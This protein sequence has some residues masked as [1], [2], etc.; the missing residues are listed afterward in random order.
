MQN[1]DDIF[2][3]VKYIEENLTETISVQDVADSIG[4]SLFYFSRIFNAATG[5]SPYDYII[6]RR[7]SQAAFDLF[8]T[9]D[10]II[11]IA[12]NYRFNN[13]ETFSRAFRKMFGILPN[14]VRNEKQKENLIVRFPITHEYL[15]HI[16]NSRN[17]NPEFIQLEEL[18][19]GG[20][21]CWDGTA[22][23]SFR[24][25]WDLLAEGK[26]PAGD[27]IPSEKKYAVVAITDH[28][29]NWRLQ[30]TGTVLA[31]KCNIPPMTLVQKIPSSEYA[32]FT[33]RGTIDTIGLTRDY[34][35]QTWLATSERQPAGE[36]ELVIFDD[37]FRGFDDA[38]SEF[39]I[40]VPLASEGKKS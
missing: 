6:R 1:L 35:Y 26:K 4:F 25:S 28:Y 37:R 2:E 34:I 10:K 33:H 29:R 12:Y 36:Y 39:F 8:D 24:H 27:S 7:L 32:S 17:R 20:V 15:T 18:H 9:N 21:S 19:I 13:P 31:D 14:R 16:N 22:G 5:H 30:I 40:C 23:T 3:S 38:E 11:D